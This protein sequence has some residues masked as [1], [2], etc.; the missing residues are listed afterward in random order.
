MAQ[1]ALT[2][3]LFDTAVVERQQ[4]NALPEPKAKDPFLGLQPIP[5]QG[6]K[7]KAASKIFGYAPLKIDTLYEPFAGSAA[8][9]LFAA[10]NKLASRYVI[11][12]SYG[13][14]ASLLKSII[15][16]PDQ[17]SKEYGKIWQQQ[18][19]NPEEHYYKIRDQFNKDENP[20]KFLFLM[21]KCVKNAVR[22]NGSGEFN[23]SPDKRRLGRSPEA[24]RKQLLYTS[25]ILKGKVTVHSKDYSEVIAAAGPKDLVYMDPPYQGTS[26]SKNPRYH[27]GIDLPKL[28][29]ELSKLNKKN[30]PYLL[31]FDG[32]LGDK[33]YGEILPDHLKLAR[34]DIHMGRSAQS[35]LN[36]G[37]SM[38]I[39]SLYIS[40]NSIHLS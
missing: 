31:S 12:D 10:N 25:F 33:K 18:L 35:T 5:Y 3:N 38:S 19:G 22:F 24:M 4:K 32:Q 13:P 29:S 1:R 20:V 17:I 7:R 21:A 6:S 9:T 37:D 36:G 28:V 30:V 16:K 39:E 8:I 27:Q 11:N 40:P 26:T 2:N 15:E 14:L 34:V 23:Q